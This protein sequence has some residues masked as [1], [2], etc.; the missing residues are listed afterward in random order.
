M[1]IPKLLTWTVQHLHMY[2]LTPFA[3]N[4]YSV[5]LLKNNVDKEGHHTQNMIFILDNPI[6]NFCQQSA[7]LWGLLKRHKN[8]TTGTNLIIRLSVLKWS[9]E[10]GYFITIHLVSKYKKMNEYDGYDGQWYMRPW[11][12]S[13]HYMFWLTCCQEVFD[14]KLLR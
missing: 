12:T 4:R 9:E 2:R 3:L 5:F 10:S 7:L 8:G 6:H 13:F 11:N 14:N 1:P